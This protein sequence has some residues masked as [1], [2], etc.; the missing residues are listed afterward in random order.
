MLGSRFT[1]GSAPI[2]GSVARNW[3]KAA[4]S[5]YPHHDFTK[6][7]LSSAILDSVRLALPVVF[8]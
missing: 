3:H 1:E 8:V 7:C 6:F 4:G 5:S 2:L